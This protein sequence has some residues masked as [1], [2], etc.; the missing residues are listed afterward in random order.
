[1]ELPYNGSQ[2]ED[3]ESNKD[4]YDNKDDRGDPEQQDNNYLSNDD[5]Y[6]NKDQGYGDN[7]R[8][9]SK[10]E[11]DEFEAAMSARVKST[12]ENT[13]CH[14]LSREWQL[15]K[16][17][18]SHMKQQVETYV[19]TTLF[20]QLKFISDQQDLG[21]LCDNTSTGNIVMNHFR[22]EDC[23]VERHRWWILYQD[24][25]KRALEQ[26]RANCNTYIKEAMIG[27]L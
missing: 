20:H 15:E 2:D 9:T 25:V 26:Q 4:E 13:A 12:L 14:R 23:P 22:I 11:S 1:M 16:E 10:D 18:D 5:H 24:V 3:E 17:C 8:M 6:N 19:H 7:R 21:N 27:T